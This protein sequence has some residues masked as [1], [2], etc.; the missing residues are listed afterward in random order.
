MSATRATS[1][2]YERISLDKWNRIKA[3]AAIFGLTIPS[4]KGRGEAFGVTIEWE[5]N[6]SVLSVHVLNPGPLEYGE[7]LNFLDSIIKGA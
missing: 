6:P 5:W 7:A 3:K 1:N 4:D 2:T